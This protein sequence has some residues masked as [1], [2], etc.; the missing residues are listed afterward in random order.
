MITSVFVYGTLKR[1]QCRESLWPVQPI[2]IREGSTRGKLYGRDDYPAMTP[3][4]D[5]VAGELWLF[6]PEQIERVLE[7]LDQI[8]GT[9]QPNQ[10]DLYHRVATEV[11][12]AAGTSLGMAWTYHYAT[13]PEAD[14]FE[15]IHASSS[16]P[17]RWP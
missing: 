2:T 3:G 16:V 11:H 5:R 1:G 6:A 15:A 17:A 14:G 9:N 7:T 13:A 4:E 12:A 8:E 10:P